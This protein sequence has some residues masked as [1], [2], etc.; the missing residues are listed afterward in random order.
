M[1]QGE[2][3]IDELIGRKIT[4]SNWRAVCLTFARILPPDI[5]CST[6]KMNKKYWPLAEWTPKRVDKI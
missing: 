5:E 4:N 6:F 1:I 3:S 2:T